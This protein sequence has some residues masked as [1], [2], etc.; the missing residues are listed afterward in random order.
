MRSAAA[1]VVSLLICWGAAGLGGVWTASS[2]DGWYRT[3]ARPSWT[4]P[5][6]LFGPVWAALY[7]AMAIS[8]WL[9]WR[10]VGFGWPLAAFAAQLAL[11]VA[12]SGLFFGLRQVGLALLDVAALWTA[13]L[14]C[15]LLFWSVS[16]VAALLMVPYLAWVSFAAALNFAIW[17]MN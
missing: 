16:T 3:L 11:N 5:D 4:P 12:W 2:V 7:T 15:I 10:R 17:R 14:T 6:A 1:L 13:I 8:A 9:V